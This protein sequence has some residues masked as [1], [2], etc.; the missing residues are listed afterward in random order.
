MPLS[1]TI[2]VAD[3]IAVGDAV[4]EVLEIGPGR[5]A[6]LQISGIKHY[7]SESA[8]TLVLPEVL[9]RFGINSNGSMTP[10]I[11]ITAPR[12]VIIKRL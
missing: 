8:D 11:N 1:L 3:R 4:V 7:I 2:H 6:M 12:E 5:Q 9:T 10:R